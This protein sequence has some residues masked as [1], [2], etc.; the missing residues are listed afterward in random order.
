MVS[1][2]LVNKHAVHDLTITCKFLTHRLYL[3]CFK[4]NQFDMFTEV[5]HNCILYTC[6]SKLILSYRLVQNK[7]L[8]SLWILFV[9]CVSC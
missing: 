4:F 9:S 6:H 8:M 3:L 5:Y 2:F 7:R 1:S